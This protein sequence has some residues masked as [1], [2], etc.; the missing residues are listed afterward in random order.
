[1]LHASVSKTWCMRL[2]PS[3]LVIAAIAAALLIKT[4]NSKAPITPSNAVIVKNAATAKMLRIKQYSRSAKSFAKNNR[5]DTS[6]CFLIDM[7]Q[8]CGSNRFFVLDMNKDSVLASGLV[9]HGYGKSSYSKINFS[10][11]PG[12]NST[13]LGKYKIGGAYNGRFGLAYKL[14]GLESSNNNALNRFVVLHSHECV[15]AAEVAPQV[16]C[17]SQGCP[18]VS[19]VFLQTLKSY[20]DK[21]SGPV[22]LW[23]FY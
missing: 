20:I 13:S 2:Y 18:T 10:N 22:L 9:T 14:H 7:K 21:S 23:I 8:P 19:P 12:S 6:C 17:M 1:M 15:P 16:I 4:E 5:F 3:L 11:I